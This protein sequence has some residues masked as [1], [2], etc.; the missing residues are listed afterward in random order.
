MFK[1]GD[2]VR[3]CAGE[4]HTVIDV[5]I[6]D[7]LE[8]LTGIPSPVREVMSEEFKKIPGMK[9]FLEEVARTPMESKLV[10]IGDA[11][12]EICIKDPN[13][14]QVWLKASHFELVS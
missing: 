7:P 13:G 10:L 8:S 6:W 1:V 12:Q 4:V 14:G 3:S 11:E 2:Q 5:R 9:T